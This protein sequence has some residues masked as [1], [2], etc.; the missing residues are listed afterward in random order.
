M[1]TQP[2]ETEARILA[3][4]AA[5]KAASAVSDDLSQANPHAKA[6]LR[7]RGNFR[8]DRVEHILELRGWS[9]KELWETIRRADARNGVQPTAWSTISNTLK[10]RHEP[11]MDTVNKFAAALDVSAQFLLG[12]VERPAEKKVT[13]PIPSPDQ[14]QLVTRLNALPADL[15]RYVIGGTTE[16]LQAVETARTLKWA[17]IEDAPKDTVREGELRELLP[18][19]SLGELRLLRELLDSPAD[20]AAG[21][22]ARRRQARAAQPATSAQMIA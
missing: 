11:T 4:E 6:K 2:T 22:P 18:T 12:L 14:W 1:D 20:A 17:M 7:V 13:Y 16:I 5:E 10:R 21:A 3:Q 15:R 8:A 9:K 19:L